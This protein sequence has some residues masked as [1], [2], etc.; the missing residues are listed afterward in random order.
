MIGKKKISTGVFTVFFET[1]IIFVFSEIYNLTEN[2]KCVFDA[3]I[4]KNTG[5]HFLKL[6]T[7]YIIPN[8]SI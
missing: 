3:P 8:N 7:Y 1:K 5:K 4:A 2:E 6:F